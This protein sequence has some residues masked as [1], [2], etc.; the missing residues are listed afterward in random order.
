[1]TGFKRQFAA[2]AFA[3]RIAHH[4]V[5]LDASCREQIEL[6]LIVNLLY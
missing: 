3:T 5:Q 2:G 4:A 6:A 1:M